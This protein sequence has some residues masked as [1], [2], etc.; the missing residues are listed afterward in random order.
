VTLSSVEQNWMISEM[1]QFLQRWW[2]SEYP[3]I[4]RGPL[5][6]KWTCGYP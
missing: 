5:R 6:S 4:A 3:L 1:S 2:L